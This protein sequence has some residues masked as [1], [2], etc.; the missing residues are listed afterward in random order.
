[1]IERDETVPFHEEAQYVGQYIGR[2]EMRKD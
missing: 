2:V 1:M